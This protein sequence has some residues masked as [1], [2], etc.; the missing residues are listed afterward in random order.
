MANQY[1][2]QL[3]HP[4]K[5]VAADCIY[6]L[7][8]V[9]INEISS[10]QIFTRSP[11]WLLCPRLVEQVHSLESAGWIRRLQ[12]FIAGPA[13]EI[14]AAFV[15]QVPGYLRSV[16]SEAMAEILHQEGRLQIA[17]VKDPWHIKCLHA[18]LAFYLVH[19]V[20]FVGQFVHGLL[21]LR[22]H[23]VGL[24][25]LWCPNSQNLQCRKGETND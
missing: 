22:N 6:D 16:L 1:P 2:D 7:P 24:G 17:G 23:R 21:Q 10:D 19:R 25:S 9:L 5:G 18:H 11:Y 3:K 4:V 12:E 13:Q 14:W 15:P 8:V 20:G